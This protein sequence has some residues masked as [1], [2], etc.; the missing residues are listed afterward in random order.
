MSLESTAWYLAR[1]RRVE[2]AE[3]IRAF[4]GLDVRKDVSRLIHEKEWVIDKKYDLERN[5]TV[6]YIVVK[7]GRLDF[8]NPQFD[9]NPYRDSIPRACGLEEKGRLI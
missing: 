3:V 9:W 1:H 8:K 7:V 4:P 2:V 5:G 6:T